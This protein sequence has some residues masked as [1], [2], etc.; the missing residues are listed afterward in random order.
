MKRRDFIASGA[1]LAATTALA[2]CGQQQTAGV[3]AA[4]H[5]LAPAD[6]YIPGYAP[7][8]ARFKGVPAL[9][10]PRM[11]R[12]IPKGY[13]QTITMLTKFGLDG[14]IRQALFPIWGHDIAISPDKRTGFFGSMERQTYVAFDPKTLDLVTLG[15]PFQPDWIGGGHSAF[16]SS[17][18]LAVTERAPRR[19]YSGRPEDHFGRVTLREP[20]SLR[21]VGDFST[22]GI[23]PHE[24]RLLDDDKHAVLANYGTTIPASGSK[25]YGTP[26][27]IVEA[28]VTIVEIDSGKLVEKYHG[29]SKEELRH[30][31]ARDRDTIFAIQTEMIKE[32]EDRA[33]FRGRSTAHTIDPTNVNN[34]SFGVAATMH[35]NAAK[36]RLEKVGSRA[37]QQLMRHGLSIE[38]DPN[39]DEVIASYPATHAVM[40]FDA[41]SGQVKQKLDCEPLGLQYPSGIAML[42]GQNYYVV[43]GYWQN[44][45]VFER[46]SHKLQRELS[47]YPVNFGHSHIVAA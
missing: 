24:I 16:L 3:S 6:I 26:R 23:A 4:R 36:G 47:H 33:F 37:D 30:L 43:A 42:P 27:H 18:V 38:Y 14:S 17:G 19:P 13:D 29:N 25:D 7:Q 44:L 32:H 8:K 45:Y 12:A 1:S 46:G 2:G 22:H 41:S 15:R 21:I 5:A 11:R 20:R 40:V 10:H 35:T 28:C 34:T 39:Y 9:E 31:C